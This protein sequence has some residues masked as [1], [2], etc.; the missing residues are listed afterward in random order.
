MRKAKTITIGGRRFDISRLPAETAIEVEFLL[1]SKVGEPMLKLAV[2][3]ESGVGEEE[4]IKIASNALGTV[5]R[6]LTAKETI[7][8]MKDVFAFVSCDGKPIE[9]NSTFADEPSQPWELL[10]EALKENFS[11]FFRG[12]LWGSI[13]K[14]RVSGSTPPAPPTSTPI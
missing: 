13:R 2:A 12:S 5:V 1:V 10:V 6:N 11:D 14:A 3:A 7:A 8:L 4:A 9:L